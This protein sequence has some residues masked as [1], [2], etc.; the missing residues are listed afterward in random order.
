MA[1]RVDNKSFFVYYFSFDDSSVDVFSPHFQNFNGTASISIGINYII[2][3]YNAIGK[4]AD[5]RALFCVNP[6]D[7]SGI[8]CFAHK[9]GGN[10]MRLKVAEKLFHINPEAVFFPAKSR[11]Y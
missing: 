10:I 4:K 2:Q 9:K 6:P 5:C 11:G 3:N 1:L 8:F 7:M